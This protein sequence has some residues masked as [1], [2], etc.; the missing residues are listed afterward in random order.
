MTSPTGF[1]HDGLL[2]TFYGDDFTGS[3]DAMEAMTAAGVSTVLFLRTPT[4]E[5]LARFADVRCVGRAGDS[6]GRSPAWMDAQ[7][8]AEF[9]ALAALG[10]PILHYKVCS[11]FDSAPQIGSIGRAIDLGVAQIGGGWSPM[12]V[13]APRLGRYQLFGNLFAVVAGVGHRLDRHPVMSRHPV[14]P[15]GE[16]DLRQH[17]AQ[18]TSRRIDLID[19]VQLRSW[20]A[21]Q[22][23]AGLVGADTPVVSIDVL[24]LETQVEAGRL[25]WEH[26]GAGLFSASSSGLCY[27]LTAYWRSL[28]LLPATPALPNLTTATKLA[29]VSGSC[30][31]ITAGQI[32]FARQ[33]GFAVARLDVAAALDDQQREAEIARCVGIAGA[34]LAEDR[35]ALIFSAEGPD[36]PSVLGFDATAAAA[37]LTREAAARRVGAALADIMRGIVL[38]SDV[39]RIVVAGGDS[40]GEVMQALDVDALTIAAGLAPG[41]PMCRTWSTQARFDGLEVTLKGGQMGGADFFVQALG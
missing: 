13:G 24:D 33:A 1:G 2:L 40:S 39:R 19:M 20:A 35:S 30:S 26:R 11:T 7:L 12:V 15:M 17:L 10:A 9:A 27:A 28:G 34:A 5:Q 37:G 4:P 21:E 36:D 6:R 41:A 32:A 23:L 16:A 25:V 18:Q 3:T 22:R 14:T 38:A 31:P 8:P 29:A